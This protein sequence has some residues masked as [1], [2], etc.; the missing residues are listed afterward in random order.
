MSD[1]AAAVSRDD[2]GASWGDCSPGAFPS[3]RPAVGRRGARDFD[4]APLRAAPSRSVSRLP[5]PRISPLC[6]EGRTAPFLSRPADSVLSRAALLSSG[7]TR[8]RIGACFVPRLEPRPRMDLRVAVG[9]ALG[10]TGSA[11]GVGSP[12]TES[13]VVVLGF[14][15]VRLLPRPLTDRR[16]GFASP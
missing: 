14:L 15:Y 10:N 11:S 8:F 7:G 6:G 1:E 3:E 16:A 9:I 13:V 2:R 12:R 5:L 4:L